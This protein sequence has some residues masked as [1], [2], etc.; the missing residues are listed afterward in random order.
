MDKFKCDVC[1]FS[2]NTQTKF[3]NH[4]KTEAHIKKMKAVAGEEPEHLSDSEKESVK[5]LKVDESTLGM[6]VNPLRQQCP[7]C[8]KLF[9]N[10]PLKTEKDILDLYVEQICELNKQIIKLKKELECHMNTE[11][12]Q[13]QLIDM[14]ASAL[15]AVRK[16]D[17]EAKGEYM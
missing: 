3:N 15:A 14:Y 12:R 9:P 1:K 11:K 16:K 10:K 13:E 7:N 17:D 4:K 8:R 5:P 2:T 6:G